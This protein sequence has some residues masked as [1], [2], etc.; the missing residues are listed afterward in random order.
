MAD[1]S[2]MRRACSSPHLKDASVCLAPHKAV[3]KGTFQGGESTERAG[4]CLKPVGAAKRWRQVTCSIRLLACLF[5]DDGR[6][7]SLQAGQ[8]SV[9]PGRDRE[10]R[11]L[12]TAQD[13]HFLCAQYRY[14]LIQRFFN[15]GGNPAFIVLKH[16]VLRVAYPPGAK[17]ICLYVRAIFKYYCTNSQILNTKH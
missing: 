8:K 3:L 9:W 11:R 4:G 15:C 6:A 1:F 5:L 17:V 13:L 7:T 12:V 16:L 10:G 2:R 14:C